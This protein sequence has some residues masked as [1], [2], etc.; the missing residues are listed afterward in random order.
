M[1]DLLG[2]LGILAVVTLAG[3]WVLISWMDAGERI[4]SILAVLP[5][6]DDEDCDTEDYDWESWDRESWWL[7]DVDD[8]SEPKWSGQ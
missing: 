3:A 5:S 8:D 6:E 1:W 4:D 7:N 2:G